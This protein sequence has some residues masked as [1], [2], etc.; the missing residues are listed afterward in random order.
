[1]KEAMIRIEEN[2][3]A[4][5]EQMAKEQQRSFAGQVRYLLDKAL[6]N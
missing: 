4:N 5:I 1:M 2:V 3:Y 6:N